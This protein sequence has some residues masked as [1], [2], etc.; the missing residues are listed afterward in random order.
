MSLVPILSGSAAFLLCMGIYTWAVI[1][2][3]NLARDARWRSFLRN[4]E[5]L[6]PDHHTRAGRRRREFAAEQRRRRA[7]AEREDW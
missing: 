3:A 6:A 1:R 2:A 5:V 7:M 4:E